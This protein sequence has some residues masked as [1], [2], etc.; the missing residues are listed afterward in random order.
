MGAFRCRRDSRVHRPAPA[1][2]PG[3]NIAL[4]DFGRATG[5][6]S[7]DRH[8]R[9]AGAVHGAA[10]HRL[11]IGFGSTPEEQKLAEVMRRELVL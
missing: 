7:N 9:A 4:N 8:H 5:R 1:G 2:A 6:D 10:A 3:L 11:L